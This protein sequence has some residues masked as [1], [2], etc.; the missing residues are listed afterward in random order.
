[1]SNGAT[2]IGSPIVSA[3]TQKNSTVY[4]CCIRNGIILDMIN[5]YGVMMLNDTKRSNVI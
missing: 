1:M 5:A 3:R 4:P 2:G